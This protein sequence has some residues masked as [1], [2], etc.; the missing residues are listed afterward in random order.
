MTGLITNRGSITA[1][2]SMVRMG[3]ETYPSK[4]QE[5]IGRVAVGY[6][7]GISLESLCTFLGK[8]D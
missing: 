7:A 4:A 2:R 6:A 1:K 8:C 5:W 3:L